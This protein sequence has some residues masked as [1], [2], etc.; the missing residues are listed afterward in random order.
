[1]E[2]CI[3]LVSEIKRESQLNSTILTEFDRESYVSD[4]F[5]FN[6][7]VQ[8]YFDFDSPVILKLDFTKSRK[9]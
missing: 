2:D 9:G 3:V 1:M 6:S 5:T 7:S 4:I 8:R